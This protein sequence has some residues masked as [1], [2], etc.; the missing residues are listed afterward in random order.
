[1]KTEVEF[2]GVPCVTGSDDI[3]WQ[4]LHRKASFF[5]G[6]NTIPGNFNRHTTHHA[7]HV[8][9]H[10][11]IYKYRKVQTRAAILQVHILCDNQ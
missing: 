4:V 6:Q 9:E 3:D 7:R 11:K 5:K 8:Q 1:M 2:H 10:I